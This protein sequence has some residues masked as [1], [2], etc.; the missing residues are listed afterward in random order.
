VPA[1]TKRVTIEMT[2]LVS[3]PAEPRK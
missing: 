3:K 1:G 2:S